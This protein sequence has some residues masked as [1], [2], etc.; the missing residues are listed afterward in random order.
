M[1][2]GMDGGKYGWAAN[3]R[4]WVSLVELQPAKARDLRGEVGGLRNMTDRMGK[5]RVLMEKK[6][7]KGDKPRPTLCHSACPQPTLIL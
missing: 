3:L 4:V 6:K 2:M 7:M 5:I 1:M